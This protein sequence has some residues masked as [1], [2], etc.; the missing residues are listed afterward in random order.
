MR[1]N[2][3]SRTNPA[4]RYY[5]NEVDG[6][7]EIRFFDPGRRPREWTEIIRPTQ[8][9]V[10]LKDGATSNSRGLD[11]KP[12]A[13]PDYATCLVFDQIEAARQFCETQVQAFPHL[14]C[15]IHDADGLVNPPLL[16]VVHPDQQYKQESGSLWSCRRKLI[17]ISLF[18]ISPP[19]V[20]IDMRRQ[21]ALVL[22]T[23]LAFNC[24]LAGLR[25][26]YCDFGVKHQERARQKRLEAQLRK[27]QGGA[28]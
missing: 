21:N 1:V 15:E 16:V 10:F 28:E 22:P 27:E 3:Q 25:C 13:N 11:G 26:L 19:L 14:R 8:C 7:T 20:W 23:F 6:G 9:T 24:I 2:R 12:F 18:L 5:T 4:V 17:A